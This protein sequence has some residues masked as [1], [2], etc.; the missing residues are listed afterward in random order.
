MPFVTGDPD[1]LEQVILN[2]AL[3]A[4]DAMPDGGELTFETD[5]MELDEDYCRTHP[6]A[7]PGHYLMISV[8]DT[9]HGIPEGIRH[10]I[11]EPFFT[12]KGRGERT[13]MGLAMVYGIV[14]NHGGSFLVYSEEGEGTTFKVYLPLAKAF[15][16]QEDDTSSSEP[17]M[18]AGKI[19]IVDDENVVL[20]V[21]VSILR[22][23]G[24][25][26]VSFLRCEEAVTYYGEH[27]GE[28]DL[29]ILDM[30]MPE[31]GGGECFRVLKEIN[32]EV[33]AVLSTGYGLDVRAQELM[34]EGM[35]GFV[36]KPYILAQ[37]SRSVAD[38]LK[39]KPFSPKT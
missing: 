37:L 4:R 23:L 15:A 29:V 32:P 28:I 26:V 16:H 8:T 24:Y 13:G 19:M 7:L 34:E 39:A 6:G 30:I 17:V 1:Q 21:A 3:N 27:S 14:I 9:G 5:A 22:N 38:A 10:R 36:R 2:L 31:M 11:F 33:K 12:T 25:E 20:N 35:V 18:G